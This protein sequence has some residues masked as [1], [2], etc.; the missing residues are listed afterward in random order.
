[1]DGI[2]YIINGIS[3]N[4]K[5]IHL[6]GKKDLGRGREAHK[7]DLDDYF[8][9]NKEIKKYFLRHMFHA[10]NDNIE[11]YFLPELNSDNKYLGNK[12][13]ESIVE[14]LKSVGFEFV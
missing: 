12:Q 1:M 4:I 5:S 3:H 10:F 9:G 13:L 8:R 11:R 14:D 7:G 6:W 2:F